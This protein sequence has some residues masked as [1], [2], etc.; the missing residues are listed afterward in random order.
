MTLEQ[1]K[2]LDCE[3]VDLE[4][5][6]EVEEHEEVSSLENLGN[7]GYNVGHTWYL[8]TLADGSEV[9]LYY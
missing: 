7:S 8:V 9:N 4:T 2:N 1:I 5:L 6:Q 3:V